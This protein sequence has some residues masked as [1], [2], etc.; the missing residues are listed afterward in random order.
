MA[1]PNIGVF[2]GPRFNDLLMQYIDACGGPAHVWLKHIDSKA[3]FSDNQL[4]RTTLS[5]A[6]KTD[7]TERDM[8]RTMATLL[9]D[10]LI[11]VACTK[12]KQLY[13]PTE[14]AWCDMRTNTLHVSASFLHRGDARAVHDVK[15]EEKEKLWGMIRNAYRRQKAQFVPFDYLNVNT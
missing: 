13:A 15:A 6:I 12:K 9:R 11:T 5:V 3:L 10:V 1:A 4:H 8:E 7:C 14:F 2:C